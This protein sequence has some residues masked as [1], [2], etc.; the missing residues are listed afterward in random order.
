MQLN[1]NT[2]ESMGYKFQ[3][4]FFYIVVQNVN[5]PVWNS[6][7]HVMLQAF[8]ACKQEV[9]AKGVFVCV[10]SWISHS[11]TN[12]R[13]RQRYLKVFWV[14]KISFSLTLDTSSTQ[15]IPINNQSY[16]SQCFLKTAHHIDKLLVCF[17]TSQELCQG[18]A[19][20][21]TNIIDTITNKCI[22]D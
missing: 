12:K 2:F 3:L 17:P 1:S 13:K 14:E 11:E 7:Y 22:Y 9:N 20:I 15:L 6:H 16:L 4:I 19:S 5:T 18:L 8:I 21:T 10:G